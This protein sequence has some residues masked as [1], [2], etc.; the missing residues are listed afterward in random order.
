MS[1]AVAPHRFTLEEYEQIVHLGVFDT[2]PRVELIEGEV[3]DMVRQNQAHAVALSLVDLQLRRVYFED[4]VIRIQSPLALGD[5]SEPEPD[6]AVVPGE[7]R[8]YL[9]SHPRSAVLVVEVAGASLHFDRTAKLAL[10]AR[11]G[12]P[13]Y[14]IVNL[15]DDVIETYRNP[16]GAAYQ[17][18]RTHRRGEAVALGKAPTQLKVSDM[19]P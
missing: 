14:W 11:H 6:I 9:T 7:P 17:E 2:G 16:A 1:A 3:I 19:L 8:D 18:A 13:D 12:I 15:V 5:A 4:H 10:Y